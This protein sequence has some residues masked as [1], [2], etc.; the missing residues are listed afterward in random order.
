[1]SKTVNK[2]QVGQVFLDKKGLHEFMTVEMEYFLP[3]MNYCNVE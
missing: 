3:D 1:M 2:S